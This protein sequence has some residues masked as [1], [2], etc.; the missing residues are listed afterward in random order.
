MITIR[1]FTMQIIE[2]KAVI[3][4]SIAIMHSHTSTLVKLCVHGTRVLTGRLQNQLKIEMKLTITKPTAYSLKYKKRFS[5]ISL[6]KNR[7][8][9]QTSVPY[10]QWLQVKQAN[11]NKTNKTIYV[12]VVGV[13][14]PNRC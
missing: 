14:V 11:K 8:R 12:S 9:T 1:A 10:Y 2:L 6:L 13:V 4:R 5:T 7:V 3:S